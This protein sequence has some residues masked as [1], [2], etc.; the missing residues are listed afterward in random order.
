MYKVLKIWHAPS[1]SIAWSLYLAVML[2]AAVSAPA[3]AQDA[4]EVQ[5]DG[6]ATQSICMD[7]DPDPDPPPPPAVD[8]VFVGQT[9]PSSM[10]SGQTYS[11]TVQ[12]MNTGTQT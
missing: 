1:Q 8:A 12:M 7:C 4:S 9:A 11:V 10:V 3:W 5:V 2:L 6:A